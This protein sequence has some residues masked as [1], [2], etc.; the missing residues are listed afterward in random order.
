MTVMLLAGDDADAADAFTVGTDRVAYLPQQVTVEPMFP[1]TVR[2]V[3][4]MGRWGA[5]GWRQGYDVLEAPMPALVSGTQALGE[6]RYPYYA[7]W[8]FPDMVAFKTAARTPA[9]TVGDGAPSEPSAGFLT[10][11]MS[12]PAST[13]TRASAAK[14]RR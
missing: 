2:D 13:A 1:A 6:P 10:S 14:G 7:E 3:V 12:T 11:T 9:I 4:A 5:L 8:E